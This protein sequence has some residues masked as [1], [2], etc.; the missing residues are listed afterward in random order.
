VFRA[1]HPFLYLI[2]DTGSGAVL[3]AGRYAGP[4]R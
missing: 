4:K 3:F 2:R 1:D